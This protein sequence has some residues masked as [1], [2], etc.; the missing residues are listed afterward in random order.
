MQG[1]QFKAEIHKR[2]GQPAFSRESKY[3]KEQ[4]KLTSL[5]NK[6]VFDT[7]TMDEN[8][9]GENITNIDAFLIFKR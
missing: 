8:T 5:N 7:L 9:L 4:T 1:P 6:N 2:Q 3:V